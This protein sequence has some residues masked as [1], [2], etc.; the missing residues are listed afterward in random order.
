[1]VSWEKLEGINRLGDLGRTRAEKHELEIGSMP[2]I[3]FSLKGADKTIT[4]AQRKCEMAIGVDDL[5][6]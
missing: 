2:I 6:K 1:M 3:E 5:L 4:A